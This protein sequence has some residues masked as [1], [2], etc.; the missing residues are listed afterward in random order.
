M[1][2]RTAH[3]FSEG[4]TSPLRC[5]VPWTV[6]GGS[7]GA[8]HPLPITSGANL[9]RFSPHLVTKTKLLNFVADTHWKFYRSF[10]KF[11][12]KPST[13]EKYISQ[14]LDDIAY[15]TENVSWPFI[16]KDGYDLWEVPMPDEEKR[17][18]PLRDLETWTG[19]R[20]ELLPPQEMLSDDQLTR[21]LKALKKMLDAYNWSLVLQIKV[22]DRIQYATIRDMFDQT[23]KVL[24]WQS[25]FFQVCRPGTAHGK[26]ALGEY[27]Q[28]AFYADLFSGSDDEELA[29]EEERKRM[30]E[31]EIRHLKRKYDDEWIKYYPHHL[32][33]EY[34]DE[35]GNPYDYGVGEEDD[36]DWD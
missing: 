36:E 25:G 11:P 1:N 7:Y 31:T 24:Q 30:L 4:R 13:M 28:C 5:R 14:L 17:H 20:K 29:P 32:D 2:I 35:D 23:A 22:P 6:S 27:C 10:L 15:A 21:L 33:P 34:D 12:K 26:C 16:R 3:A 18:A 9:E 19:I 8:G